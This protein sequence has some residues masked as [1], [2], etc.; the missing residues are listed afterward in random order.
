MG[1]SLSRVL[2]DQVAA[3]Q[4]PAT[5]RL[6][7]PG[8]VVAF[9]LR[10]RKAAGYASAVAAARSHG[11][12]AMERLTGGRAAVYSEGTIS[13]TL[14]LPDPA[15][16]ERTDRRFHDA[17]ELVR[18]A[19]ASLGID[20]RI[21]EVPGEYCPGDFSVN[22][23]GEVKLAGIG[24]RMI[25]G[26][27]HVG[28]V[29]VASGSDQLRHVLEP[30][31]A[32]LELEWNPATVGAAEDEVATAGRDRIELALLERIKSQYRLSPVPLDEGT[33]QLAESGA[34]RFR[35]PD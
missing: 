13:L 10:D 35:S 1:P 18:S 29:I 8:R 15:P 19:L 28:M 26:A 12:E 34:A 11:F 31:H 32:A 27:A 4:R 5:V 17:A 25:R 3:G 16:A 6:S 23:R 14:T 2:L 22:A 9:G 21:G 7:R 24:Q 33:L 30:V 20:S